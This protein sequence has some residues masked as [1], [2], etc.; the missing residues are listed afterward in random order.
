MKIIFDFDGLDGSLSVPAGIRNATEG[1]VVAPPGIASHESEPHTG[2]DAITES[3][4]IESNTSQIAFDDL[5]LT[6]RILKDSD[7]AQIESDGLGTAERASYDGDSSQVDSDDLEITARV[8]LQLETFEDNHADAL[9]PKGEPSPEPFF[10]QIGN[11]NGSARESPKTPSLIGVVMVFLIGLLSGSGILYWWNDRGAANPYLSQGMRGLAAESADSG[12]LADSGLSVTEQIS[13][14]PAVIEGSEPSTTRLAQASDPVNT[15]P[16]FAAARLSMGS[17][18][19][20]SVQEDTLFPQRQNNEALA[21]LK[22]VMDLEEQSENEIHQAVPISNRQE[23]FNAWTIPFPFSELEVRFQTLKN[24]LPLV[25][26]CDGSL[27]ITGHTCTLGSA[28][29]NYYVGL[30]RAKSVRDT[31]ITL[32][33]SAQRLRVN[34]AGDE[35]PVATNDTKD[36]RQENR[37]AVIHCRME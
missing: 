1:A 16:P 11:N 34:S 37:R 13:R 35:Q 29:N 7:S 12:E 8:P 28:E 18:Q 10:K 2:I 32:G 23:E 31:L 14:L 27:V 3:V 5:E 24:F 30:A 6:E 20:S 25:M 36:G 33:V 4:P 19:A 21:S 17:Q 9:S 15:S 22:E 26:K